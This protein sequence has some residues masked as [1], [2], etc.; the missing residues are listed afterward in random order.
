MDRV[1]MSS[2]DTMH[3]GLKMSSS[4]V[5]GATGNDVIHGYRREC[6]RKLVVVGA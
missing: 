5:H 1:D 6:P 3:Q 2:H 4:E